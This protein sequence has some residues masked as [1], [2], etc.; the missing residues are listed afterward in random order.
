[1]K[2][3]YVVLIFI[4][5]FQEGL[6]SFSQWRFSTWNDKKTQTL[7]LNG[8]QVGEEVDVKKMILKRQRIKI[9][10]AAFPD[11]SYHWEIVSAPSSSKVI[12]KQPSGHDLQNNKFTADK[13]G[14]YKLQLVRINGRHR[15]V[16]SEVTILASENM[17]PI[18]DAG[19]DQSVKLG[20]KVI[21]SGVNSYDPEKSFIRYRWVQLES[22]SGSYIEIFGKENVKADFAPDTEGVYVFGLI[23]YDD[24]QSSLLDKVNIVVRK[25][26]SPPVSNP[27]VD[28]VVLLGQRVILSGNKSSD[29]DKDSLSFKWFFSSLP[30]NSETDIE[31][32]N[33]VVANFYPD[34]VGKYLVGLVVSDKTGN[35]STAFMTV[36]VL[37]K[38]NIPPI[39]IIGPDR[40]GVLN[41]L[42]KLDGSASYDDDQDDLLFKWKIVSRP[43]LSELN[44]E[45]TENVATQFIPDVIGDYVFQLVV[46][47]GEIDSEPS[48]IAI[49]V[50]DDNQAPIAK[51]SLLNTNK[52]FFNIG[53][54][55]RFSGIDSYDSEGGKLK[56]EWSFKS[57]PG[58]SNATISSPHDMKS[59]FVIDV[60]GDYLI[61]LVVYDSKNKASQE[62]A[63][64]ILTER[65]VNEISKPVA[66]AGYN[67]VAYL[68]TTVFLNGR[69]SG[70]SRSE[71]L[72]YEWNCKESPDGAKVKLLKSKT[73][74]PSYVA[75]KEG[76]YIFTLRVSNEI[77]DFHTDN[78]SI[79]VKRP[80]LSLNWIRNYEYSKYTITVKDLTSNQ[81]VTNS[82]LDGKLS[83]FQIE[84]L[85]ANTMY[86]VTLNGCSDALCSDNIIQENVHIKNYVRN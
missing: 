71:K 68:G 6:Q 52:Q 69:S 15:I 27:G 32:A 76:K 81:Y 9:L 54:S 43:E 72:F 64:T 3:L 74:S 25:D 8:V 33:S 48:N 58:S 10:G 46:N 2:I 19:L 13:K 70:S 11:G 75:H 80:G 16:E 30:E 26:N 34:L 40:D 23:V 53:T 39:A 44:L 14:T 66:N 42:I 18:A 83:S 55:I 78:V 56:Y 22:P 84:D 60:P 24:F 79:V 67:I 20:E 82:E 36:K 12:K 38:E 77:G 73:S 41:N 31:R 47:D 57:K 45:N 50:S 1:M 5:P 29:S 21:L 49:A 7:S 28:Q 62:S 37:E 17:P 63:L 4:L 35:E 85:S 59:S 86:R 65:P 61:S 51:A